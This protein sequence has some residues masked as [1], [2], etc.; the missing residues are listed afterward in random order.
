MTSSQQL[1]APER[2]AHQT[3]SAPK[4]RDRNASIRV[5]FAQRDVIGKIGGGEAASARMLER[6]NQ[7][8]VTW[9]VSQ[10]PQTPIAANFEYASID[11]TFRS[12]MQER[13]RSIPAD[14]PSTVRAD[15]YEALS[16]AHAVKGQEFD[17]VECPDYVT[18]GRFLPF[19]FAEFGVKY[20]R[21]VCSLHGRSSRT[22]EIE[23]QFGEVISP[24][25]F[26]HLQSAE[27]Q[28]IFGA[29]DIRYGFSERYV[30]QTRQLEPLPIALVDPLCALPAVHH[31]AR[32]ARKR[33]LIWFVARQDRVKGADLFLAALFRAG[34]ELWNHYAMCG[35][36]VRFK[37]RASIFEAMGYCR[38]R[39]MPFNYRGPLPYADVAIEAYQSGA[40]VVVPSREETF[41]LV[42]L[43]A[44]LH[45]APV[46]LSKHAGAADF[47]RNRFGFHF[48]GVD[49]FDPFDEFAAARA[50]RSMWEH[51]P[52]HREALVKALRETDLSPQP[53]SLFDAYSS[54]PEFDP[55]LR[56]E[57]ASDWNRVMKA[58]SDLNAK[59]VTPIDREKESST[60]T[61]VTGKPLFDMADRI[62]NQSPQ[63][64]PF[65]CLQETRRLAALSAHINRARIYRQLARCEETTRPM[66][67]AA[68]RLRA[69]RM[70]AV[71]AP[72]IADLEQQL[73]RRGFIEESACVRLWATSQDDEPVRNYLEQRRR[74]SL[75]IQLDDSEYV[76]DRRGANAS[77]VSI[78]VSMYNASKP[79][80]E[81]FLAHL[82]PV[83]MAAAGRAEIV[84]V[85]SG[86]TLPQIELL[87]SVP[88]LQKM[89]YVIVRSVERETIQTAWNRGIQSARGE[90]VTC[91]GVDEGVAESALDE[92]TGFL[93]RHPEIDWV[94][95]DAVVSEVD[96]Q[97]RWRRD[98]MSYHRSPYN[99]FSYLNDCTYINYVGGLYRRSIHHRFGWYD[100]SFKGAGDTEFKCRIFPFIQ[101]A[102][103][104][105]TLGFYFDFPA[106]RVT[107]SANIEIED[108]RAWYLFRTPG[109]IDY[110]MQGK[111]ASAWEQLFWSALAGRRC[112]TGA[113]ADCDLAFAVNVLSGLLRR[114]PNHAL[115][116]FERRLQTLLRE[117]RRLQDWPGH[118]LHGA[119]AES[120][121]IERSRRFFRRCT[122]M[123]PDLTFPPDYRS[124]AF[125]FA[126]SW[127][128]Q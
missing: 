85:D 88:S 42:A 106:E 89:P 84:F 71:P 110:L 33:G 46:L 77:K 95:S 90:Y 87:R 34:E 27:R 53:D 116:V 56:D 112:W 92:L 21:L 2:H 125:F 82:S 108:L 17:V 103:L 68:Y 81:H 113:K 63:Q 93:D 73:Q 127:T 18:Y 97:G 67:A 12:G 126:H 58:Y 118:G 86:S 15:F 43:E 99:R 7:A 119:I 54:R 32:R 44:L 37:N 10:P 31:S 75:E 79:V 94:T 47:I 117:M 29:A 41:S 69:F 123:R 114:N 26:Q 19:A 11:T 62:L 13:V 45:G 76:V 96:A 50:I 36:S 28:F 24:A 60:P 8:V 124:D 65:L 120:D 35:P 6:T 109:G 128:W 121:L 16:I 38:R 1:I 98:V 25:Q 22:F 115:C 30:A 4:L 20:K 64:N 61:A 104:P 91:L 57:A 100:G 78:I 122:K 23:N 111:E 48:E 59:T 51:W 74:R 3:P 70:G 105:K 14:I 101:T 72:E 80:V 5:L 49:I 102:A 39:G 55:Q 107:N 40:F 9:P 52:E 66:V 83:A